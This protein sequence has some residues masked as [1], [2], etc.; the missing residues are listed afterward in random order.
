MAY[1]VSKPSPS[2]SRPKQ[3]PYGKYYPAAGE[4][5]EQ[6]SWEEG[7]RAQVESEMAAQGL[8]GYSRA[9]YMGTRLAELAA[10]RDT[11]EPGAE[12]VSARQYAEAIVARDALEEQIAES[13]RRLSGPY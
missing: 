3:D 10:E 6:V 4:A 5:P 8:T 11:P 12:D 9:A 1:T 2:D 7:A 13:F